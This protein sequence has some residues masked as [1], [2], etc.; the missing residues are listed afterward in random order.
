M[1]KMF[2]LFFFVI[3]TMSFGVV[4]AE[5]VTLDK[6]IEAFNSGEVAKSYQDAGGSIVATYDED[7][8]DI[9]VDIE[10]E[11]Y[12]VSYEIDGTV[13]SATINSE[14]ETGFLT[15]YLYLGL[16]DE[17]GVLH[18]YASGEL[19]KTVNSEEIAEYTLEKEGFETVV[20]SETVQEIK[21]DYSKKVPLIDF[22]G[23]YVEVEDLEKYKE[24]IADD[25]Q[26]GT[27]KGDI[28]ISKFG[29]NGEYEIIVGEKDELTEASYQSILSM[30]EV[31]FDER[32]VKYFKENYPSLSTD[33]SFDGF[34]IKLNYSDSENS[35]VTY[36]ETNGYQVIYITVDK[37]I[38]LSKIKDI[39][40][41]VDSTTEDEVSE[42][43][44][45][46]ATEEAPIVK[47]EN[48]IETILKNY[49]LYIGIGA[50]VL[51]LLILI[52]ALA[53]KKKKT[54]TAVDNY[55]TVNISMADYGKVI[56]PAVFNNTGAAQQPVQPQVPQPAQ[57]PMMQQQMMQQSVNN[58]MQQQVPPQQGQM[59]VNNYPN[60]NGN[61][62]YN[63]Q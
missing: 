27:T 29:Y 62:Y 18:G 33:E 60:N 48:T 50:G 47:K 28:Y 38:V 10:T 23:V 19:T 40:I 15:A 7:S 4:Y 3:L 26:A 8:I 20:V 24:Y 58:G 1:K 37:E 31:M 61:N 45:K 57:Q 56:R 63:G 9:A 13:I 6:I 34:D 21:I 32:A 11:K 55:E 5:E 25:G 42:N 54:V 2:R 46:E 17:I 16:I 36:L 44:E 30:I 41:S 43:E 49:G 39:E 59:P 12:N 53:G 14:E 51:V 22:T 52:I 35:D